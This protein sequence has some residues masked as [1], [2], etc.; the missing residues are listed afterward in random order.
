MAVIRV[1]E[2]RSWVVAGWVFRYLSDNIDHSGVSSTL[3]QRITES[4]EPSLNYMDVTDLT[5]KDRELLTRQVSRIADDLVQA[6][7]SSLAEPSF[8][9]GLV[10]RVKELQGLLEASLAAL[11][12][13]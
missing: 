5:V 4:R 9:D 3:A 13:T 12:Q 11:D 8:H 10:A 6:G 7:P 1:D 2:K